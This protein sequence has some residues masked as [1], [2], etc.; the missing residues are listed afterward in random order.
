MGT[1]LNNNLPGG[2]N[3]VST[4]NDG[5]ALTPLMPMVVSTLP[6]AGKT[7][8]CYLINLSISVAYAPGFSI[9]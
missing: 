4:E 9:A 5:V 1:A 2:P 6:S 7:L 3:A 8:A